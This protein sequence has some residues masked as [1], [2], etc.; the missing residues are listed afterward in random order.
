MHGVTLNGKMS[1][2]APRRRQAPLFPTSP[3]VRY[4]SSVSSTS[5]NH[6]RFTSPSPRPL[7][8]WPC[9]FLLVLGHGTHRSPKE[10]ISSWRYLPR[11]TTGGHGFQCPTPTLATARSILRR[12]TQAQ[13]IYQL[14]DAIISV[15]AFKEGIAP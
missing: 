8:C 11:C 15:G 13:A 5:V 12:L 14:L 1:V 2:A 7:S 10:T 6:S 3:L 9:L 4:T